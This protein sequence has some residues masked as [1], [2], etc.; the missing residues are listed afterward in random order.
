MQEGMKRRPIAITVLF[1]TQL[2]GGCSRRG[3]PVPVSEP[4][5]AAGTPTALAPN[6]R[7]QATDDLVPLYRR[8]GLLAEGGET[9]FVASL[10]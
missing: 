6:R 8:M 3:G 2:I 7:L 4:A 9:P 10:W 1:A 5:A